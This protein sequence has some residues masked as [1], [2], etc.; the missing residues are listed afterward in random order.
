MEV[1]EHHKKLK[2]MIAD[3]Q[4]SIGENPREEVS[5]HSHWQYSSLISVDLKIQYHEISTLF[6]VTRFP[7]RALICSIKLLSIRLQIRVIAKVDFTYFV[8]YEI[9]AKVNLISQNFSKTL[10]LNFVNKKDL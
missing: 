6:L 1:Q 8:K 10:F 7:L 3:I 9:S 4:K 2:A 5:W